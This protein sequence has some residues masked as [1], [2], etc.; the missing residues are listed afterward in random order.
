MK[1]FLSKNSI[2]YTYV[3]ITEGMENLSRFLK[4]RDI[5]PEFVPIKEKG[6]V[7]LPCIMVNDGEKF[8]FGRPESILEEIKK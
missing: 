1:E 4:Y 6:R 7:G 3:E 5:R 2:D 8:L